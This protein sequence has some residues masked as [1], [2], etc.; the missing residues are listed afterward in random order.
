M[1]RRV[2]DLLV[3]VETKENALLKSRLQEER[4]LLETQRLK[5]IQLEEIKQRKSEYY[6]EQKKANDRKAQQRADHEKALQGFSN[7]DEEIKALI[8][9]KR[10]QG[11]YQD[12]YPLELERLRVSFV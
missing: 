1:K 7:K 3:Q 4:D 12:I 5:E 10:Q 2:K 11:H 6:K 8:E 9:L